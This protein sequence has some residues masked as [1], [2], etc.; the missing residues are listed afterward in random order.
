MMA[1]RPP[2]ACRARGG[3]LRLRG[4]RHR[5]WLTSIITSCSEVERDA[6]DGDDQGRLSQARDGIPSRTATAAARIS[7]AK[8]KAISEAYECLKDPQKRAAYDRFGHA[9]FQN[10]GGGGFGG[11]AGFRRLL[12]HFRDRSSASSCGGAGAAR[13]R[14]ARRRPA[15]RPGDQRSRRRSTASRV[16]INVDSHRR[17][18]S[19][20]TASGA[21]PG[22][23]ARACQTVRRPRQGPR[24]AGLLRGRADL[25]DL[26]RR[27][28]GDRRSLPDLP[29]RGPG[30]AS[31]RR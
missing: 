6:D 26:P 15:L 10:G 5:R 1:T 28:R 30:R 25:P 24:A 3:R 13:Q 8:F 14:A 2:P 11:G 21:K 19:P 17:A 16:E 29:R 22:T 12:R 31:A 4:R 9:A 20:A 18:A 23:S 7:E 27:G